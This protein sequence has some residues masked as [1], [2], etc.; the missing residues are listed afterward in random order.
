MSRKGRHGFSLLEV[1][2]ATSI[3][4]GSAIVLLELVTIGNKHARSARDLTKSQLICQTKLNEILAGAIPAEAVRPTPIEDD[5]EWVYWVELSPI[6][7]DGL[8]ALEVNV[9]HEPVP[10]K[11]SARFKLVRWI[12]EPPNQ[13]SNGLPTP[14]PG[15]PLLQK[16]ASGRT[17]P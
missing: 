12:H 13:F 1:L 14:P 5:P 15:D 2:L 11:Q 6:Q 8:V 3:L 10:P 9:A 17:M 4:I 16:A 7:K